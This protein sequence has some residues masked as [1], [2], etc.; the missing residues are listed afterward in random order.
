VVGVQK[1]HQLLAAFAADR[2]GRTLPGVGLSAVNVDVLSPLK[3]S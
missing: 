3:R 2:R 1:A